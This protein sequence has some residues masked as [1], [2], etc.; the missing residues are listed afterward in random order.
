MPLTEE[1]RKKR[2]ETYWLIEEGIQNRIRAKVEW[3]FDNFGGRPPD[4]DPMWS[5]LNSDIR[6]DIVDKLRKLGIIYDCMFEIIVQRG[7][8]I[9]VGTRVIW[10]EEV[11]KVSQNKLADLEARV[12]TLEERIGQPLDART[13]AV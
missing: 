2:Q 1:E 13:I 5:A 4:G 11:Q 12:A 7:G 6:A 9:R 8:T 10:P 3:A